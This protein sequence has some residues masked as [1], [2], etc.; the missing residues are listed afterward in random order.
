MKNRFLVK[1]GAYLA[2]AVVFVVLAY[3]YCFPV[4]QGKVIYAGDNVTA[5][6]VVHEGVS[7]TEATGD[8]SWW[9]GSMFSGMPAFQVGGGHYASDSWLAPLKAF[10]HR[11]H[12]HTAWVFIIYFLCFFALLRSFGVDKW[13]CLVGAVVIALSS[14]F[15]VVI[16]AGH[17][18]KTSTIALI[19]VVFAGF[20]LIFRKKYA[21]GVI[22]ALLFT[23]LGFSTHPQMAYY[24]FMMMGV[25]WFAELYTHIRERRMKDFAVATLLFAASVGL[26]MGTSSANVFANAEYVKET[27]RGG[28]SD[29]TKAEDA[30]NKTSGLDLDYATQ[31]SYGIDE[32]MT[33]LIPGFKGGASGV[34]VGTD[35]KL[36]KTLVKGGVPARSAA[37]FCQQTPLYWGEQ[38]FTAGNVYVGAIVCFL[39]LLGLLLVR[40]PYKWAL[41]VATLFSIFLAWGHN[42]MGLTAF[43]FKYFPLY[44]KFRAVSS[45]LIVAEIAMPLLGFL[46]LKQLMEGTIE[47]KQVKR[48]LWISGGVTAGICLFFALFGGLIYDFT[49]S[50]DVRFTSRIPDWIYS[51]ILDQRASLF[52]ADCLRSFGLIAAAFVLLW[53]FVE[54]KMRK[55]W[56]IALLGVLMVADLWA[57]DKR[58][59]ND[60]NFMPSYLERRAFAMQPW[61]QAILAD[62]DP[63]FRVY[64][65]SGGDPFSDARTSYRLKSLGGYSAAKLRRYQDL[66]DVYLSKGNLN[67]I[68]ML[69]AKYIV[70][71][72]E[73]G[74]P[75]PQLNPGAMGNAW[76][77]SELI[78]AASADE[79]M[80][81]LGEIDLRNVAVVDQSFAEAVTNWSPGIPEEASI[82]LE[83]YTPRYLD[84]RSHASAPGTVV[85]SE[86]YYPYGW[87]VTI[88]GVPAEHFR[89]DYTLRA[90]HIPAGDH[91]IHFEFAPDSV[92]KGDTL[93]IVCILAMYLIIL[94]LIGINVYKRIKTAKKTA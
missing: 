26:G 30:G 75:Q 92:R 53:I 1:Y 70:V 71:P 38:P 12:S 54:G 51:A 17:N 62:P 32:T 66:I 8:H 27:M 61:E 49:S 13:L 87:K 5:E 82:R 21:L 40:G 68:S 48:A 60:S 45:I 59:L 22:F 80:A 90:L 19:S 42:W 69:N 64:N 94:G 84:Y 36:Y 9:T 11:G 23:A 83:K 15:I 43:F 14:Y 57:V 47:R 31:W 58:Y 39:F 55:G 52:R 28:H 16:A 41:L 29:L 6:S 73:N 34:D 81:L 18:G 86:I 4:L 20:Y 72:D 44:N 37:D 91:A 3:A 79:E 67:V 7:Y 24:L 56:L 78:P 76:F 35:S 10:F 63:H 88:D 85:F 89:A 2:A 25:C 33:L 74:Q 50:Q 77:V 46:A 93:A 65:V